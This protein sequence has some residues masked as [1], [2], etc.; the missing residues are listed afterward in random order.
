[1][2]TFIC[3]TLVGLVIFG[4]V[5]GVDP[6]NVQV[7]NKR[8]NQ[9]GDIE[10]TQ[11]DL[12]AVTNRKECICVPYYRCDPGHWEKTENDH[13][14]RFMY[15]CCYGDEAFEYMSTNNQENEST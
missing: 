2:D 6:Q 10:V 8:Q 4:S 14:S 5:N 13:C 12:N 9:F 1:M 11:N 15:I 7:I 3:I